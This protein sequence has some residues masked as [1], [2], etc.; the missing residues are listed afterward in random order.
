M[1]VLEVRSESTTKKVNSPAKTV[2][3]DNVN[4]ILNDPEHFKKIQEQ[5]SKAFSESE[6]QNNDMISKIKKDME[7]KMRAS[8]LKADEQN[9]NAIDKIMDAIASKSKKEDSDLTH[10]IGRVSDMLSRLK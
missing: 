4:A 7:S 10:K 2:S 3:Q 6:Q 1:Q 5:I 9:A 8:I